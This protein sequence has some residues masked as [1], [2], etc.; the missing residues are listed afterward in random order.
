MQ[1]MKRNALIIG[2]ILIGAAIG[3]ALF[4]LYPGLMLQGTSF[5]NQGGSAGPSPQSLGNSTTT[6]AGTGGGYGMGP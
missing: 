2:V 4:M 1:G 3:G 6:T 5:Q